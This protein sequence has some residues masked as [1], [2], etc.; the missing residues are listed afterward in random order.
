MN[1]GIIRQ[2]A[3]DIMRIVWINVDDEDT[4]REIGKILWDLYNKGNE[5]DENE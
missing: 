4:I 2:K 5:L 1:A 3:R